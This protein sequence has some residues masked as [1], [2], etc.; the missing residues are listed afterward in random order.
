MSA[1]ECNP[2]DICSH[3]VLLSLT[4]LRHWR[5]NGERGDD[6]ALCAAG[7][8]KNGSNIGNPTGSAAEPFAV[9]TLRNQP[10]YR[11]SLRHGGVHTPH[12]VLPVAS[13]RECTG[14]ISCSLSLPGNMTKGCV[15]SI[16]IAPI[17]TEHL[18]CCAADDHH[19]RPGLDPMLV[20]VRAN[21]AR[22]EFHCV[23]TKSRSDASG[24]AHPLA[25]RAVR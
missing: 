16:Q 20:R 19:M 13:S 3:W 10:P 8:C 4:Q 6:Q 18:P 17:G 12:R 2:E 23:V 9:S 14:I 24:L 22:Q 15:G 11:R 21:L 7:Q 1:F 25:S 5:T